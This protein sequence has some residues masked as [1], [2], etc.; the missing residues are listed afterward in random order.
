MTDGRPYHVVRGG[1]WYTSD[2]YLMHHDIEP[3][4]NGNVLALVVEKKLMKNA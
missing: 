3:L 1:N 2:K 4:P